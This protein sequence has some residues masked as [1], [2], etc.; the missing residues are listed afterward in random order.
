MSTADASAACE[1]IDDA[2]RRLSREFAATGD[3]TAQIARLIEMGRG[4]PGLPEIDRNET[5][6]IHGCQSQLWL[7]GERQGDVMTFGADS[8]SLVMRGLLA[9][10][11]PLYDRR[12]PADI[13]NYLGGDADDL[14]LALAPSRASG[15]RLLKRRI[16]EAAERAL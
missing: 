15:L 7:T 2:A 4:F 3:M 6:R 10:I 11:V 9:I 12:R 13:L 5:T 8:D 16:S 14:I 1:T